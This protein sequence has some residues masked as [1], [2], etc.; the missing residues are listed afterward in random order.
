MTG[1]A[2]P[3]ASVDGLHTMRARLSLPMTRRVVGM[4]EGR[5]R[6]TLQGHGQDFDDLSRYSPGDDIGDID[7]S[8]SARAGFPLI[9]R[10]VHET[11]INVVLAVD[12]G[13]TM[14][15]L[16]Q[17]GESKTVVAME[18]ARL[19]ALLAQ[20]GSDRLALVAA[21]GERLVVRPGRTGR[22]HTQMLL[23]ELETRFDVEGPDTDLPRLLRAVDSAVSRRSLVV[24]ITDG[25]HPAAETDFQ[26]LRRLR[27][28]HEVVVAAVLDGDPRWG[29]D[30]D[31]GWSAPRFL[32]LAP[33][34]TEQIAAAA[35]RREAERTL[36]VRRLGLLSVSV[37]H[38]SEVLSAFAR[39]LESNRVAR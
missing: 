36:A 12:T 33:H 35:A 11:T 4:M 31:D 25:A 30:V 37:G 13:R 5:H 1:I 15:A 6:S 26:A 21:D 14:S 20:E 7:W 19:F 27:T 17:G 8:S 34:V 23:R 16:A 28:R 3:S 24:L 10:Y 32:L 38:S 9:K 29:Q 22:A 2:A 39:T 18:L